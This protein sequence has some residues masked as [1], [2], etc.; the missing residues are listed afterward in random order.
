MS[1][2]NEEKSQQAA[3]ENQ[4]EAIQA[5][6]LA[7]AQARENEIDATQDNGGADK[8][9]QTAAKKTEGQKE[10]DPAAEAGDAETPGDKPEVGN[11]HVAGNTRLLQ[12]LSVLAD[13]H[14]IPAWHQAALL[15]YMGWQDDK[16][17]TDED[18]RKALDGLKHRRIGGGRK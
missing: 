9:A 14:R 16:R 17:V 18:Y 5:S 6:E 13:R 3:A 12:N 4:D 8:S 2:K 1:K 15:R 10:P 7:N 11:T